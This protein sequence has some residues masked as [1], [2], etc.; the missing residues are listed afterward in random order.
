MLSPIGQCCR[1]ERCTRC[2]VITGG[3]P[4][5]TGAL[6]VGAKLGVCPPHFLPPTPCAGFDS[7]L[8]S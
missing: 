5:L 3:D 6:W 4:N 7:Q 8:F 2:P 1:A